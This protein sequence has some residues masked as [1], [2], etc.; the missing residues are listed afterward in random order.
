[1]YSIIEITEDKYYDIVSGFVKV[2]DGN[3]IATCNPE[4]V[5]YSCIKVK[6]GKIVT[7]SW[8]VLGIAQN[9]LKKE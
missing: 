4:C 6:E 3:Y 7:N 1:M 9:W 2:P 8:R 5:Y